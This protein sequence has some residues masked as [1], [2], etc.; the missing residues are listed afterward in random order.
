MRNYFFIFFVMVLFVFSI[1][2]AENSDDGDDKNQ[3]SVV[4]TIALTS[5]NGGE[6]WT[7]GSTQEIKW[8]NNNSG[9]VKIELHKSEI[10]VLEIISVTENDGSYMWLIPS[11]LDAGL[12]YKIKIVRTDNSAV[13]DFSDGNF[14]ISIV[15]ELEVY[16]LDSVNNQLSG[17]AG[18]TLSDKLIVVAD[19]NESE[20]FIYEVFGDGIVDADG[21]LYY[22][23]PSDALQGTSRD[24]QVL[25]TSIQSGKTGILIGSVYVIEKNILARGTIGSSGG[26]VSSDSGI[27]VS[28]GPGVLNET[29][30]TI[31]KGCDLSGNPEINISSNNQLEDFSIGLPD[32]ND[33]AQELNCSTSAQSSSSSQSSSF[34]LFSSSS[35]TSSDFEDECEKSKWGIFRHIWQCRKKY[36][37][38]VRNFRIDYFPADETAIKNTCNS[39][40]DLVCLDIKPGAALF[41]SV[42][43]DDSSLSEKEPVL[44]I[45]GFVQGD[46]MGGGE[47][48]WNLFPQ[49]LEEIE[50]KNYVAFE[51]K[52][53]SN[54]RFQDIAE[55]LVSAVKMINEKTGKKINIVAHSF[56]G[57]LVRTVL[58]R[59]NATD[60]TNY[61]ASLITFGTPHSG[62]FYSAVENH[63]INFPRGQ[64][65]F[66]H[67][68]CRQ[69]SCYQMGEDV[70]FSLIGTS[71]N[72]RTLANTLVKSW[73]GVDPTA[74]KI[75]ADLS[76]TSS[77]PLPNNLPIKVVIGLVLGRDGDGL[78]SYSGQRFHP[79]FTNSGEILPL[80]NGSDEYGGKISEEILDESYA[81]SSAVAPKNTSTE[82]GVDSVNHE[83][84]KLTRDWLENVSNE[85]SPPLVTGKIPDTGQ[86]TSY[87]S[88]FGEDSDYTINPPSYTDNGNG[89]VTD[90]VTGL[91]W[92]QEDDNQTRIWSSALIY[93]NNSTLG[94]YTD[95]RLPT[96]KELN[97][98][99]D[100][101]VHNLAINPV[102]SGT[103]SSDYWSSASDYD[104]DYAWYTSFEYGGVSTSYKRYKNYVRCVRG[105]SESYT[106]PFDFLDNRN[107]TVT[108]SSTGLVWQQEDDNIIS[109]WE[110][111]ISYCEGLTFAGKGDWR[112]PNV[113]E[114]Q[115]LVDYSKDN[116]ATDLSLFPGTNSSDYWSSTT[117]AFNMIVAWCVSFYDGDMSTRYK[118]FNNY[119]RCVRGGQ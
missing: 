58:Q 79:D 41:S 7:I 106:L 84:F 4:S 80:L 50:G 12:D 3:T 39:I 74:G 100:Y 16:L 115:T 89:T 8:T 68:L 28:V 109:R 54:A 82:V 43:I 42:I 32:P 6:N 99:V 88:T 35:S 20:T 73:I 75:A 49:L 23:I 34:Q 91:V 105:G 11:N 63:E 93:C 14:E 77:N 116:P 92:Q 17:F 83:S 25:V 48:S 95:W 117:T 72:L 67:R 44:F 110:I 103:N 111:A 2:C 18:D 81:H 52:W 15:N 31:S 46:K 118:S 69:I 57:I 38:K 29:E 97:N 30:I 87:T 53:R 33:L 55:D 112:L 37:S 113:K 10:L 56:G 21:N 61:V 62:I 64:D 5:P 71:P 85:N 90:N 86:I 104:T 119:V 66:M 19:A 45:H 13:S 60:G 101:E 59:L 114:L 102:F 108:H 1:Q 107:G 22:Q 24:F 27:V 98:I 94:A 70:D 78:I 47:D 96:Q 76:K 36:F 9:S 40:F 26:D 51:F 65:S